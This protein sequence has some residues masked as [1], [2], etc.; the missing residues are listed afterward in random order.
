MAMYQPFQQR[1]I[2][3]K[4]ALDVKIENLTNFIDS[5]TAGFINLNTTDK[6]DL[7][8][9]LQVMKQYSQILERRI[10]RFAALNT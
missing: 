2:D 8:S 9:Q 1:V 7:I 5:K 6:I 4:A 10:G 3:E